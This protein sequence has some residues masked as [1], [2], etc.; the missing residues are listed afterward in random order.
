MTPL[1]AL[2]AKLARG[3]LHEALSTIYAGLGRQDQQAASL[4]TAYDLYQAQGDTVSINSFRRLTAATNLLLMG[5][6]SA[7]YN[8][9][10]SAATG[11]MPARSPSLRSG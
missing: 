7:G 6:R 10:L 8:V 11:T 5:D 9:T 1:A 3:Y 2:R 4:R